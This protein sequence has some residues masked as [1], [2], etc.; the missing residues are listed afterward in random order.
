MSTTKG[1]ASGPV[2]FM[3]V[4]NSATEAVKQGG[5]RRGANMGILRVDHPD[6]IEFIN[7]K[8]DITQ[9]TN[10]NISVAITDVFMDA[11]KTNSNYS[12]INPLNNQV[13]GELNS[14]EVFDMIVDRAHATGEPGVIFIDRINQAN[15]TP[16]L[17]EIESTNPCGEQPLLPYEACNLGS[18]NLNKVVQKQS[19]GDYVMDYIALERITRLAVR[20]LD[21]IIDA[22]CFPLTEI[23]EMVQKT[24]KIGLGVMGWADMLIKLGIPY[25]SDEALRQAEYVMSAILEVGREESKLLAKEK[26]AYKEGAEVRNA[27][28]T[29]I[30]PTGTISIIA[31]CSG[32]VEPLFGIAFIRNQAGEEMADV[33]PYFI[34]VAKERGFYSEELMKK[35]AKQGGVQGL[36]EVPEDI[37]RVWVTS[38]DIS[39]EYHIRMQGAFQK[40]SDS[41]VSKT[42]NFCHSATKKEVEEAY[43]LAYELGCKGTTVYR[44]GS[45]F[46]QAL[47][48]GSVKKEGEV[49][50]ERPEVLRGET[51]KKHIGCGNLY[52]TVNKTEN[53]KPFEVFTNTGKKGGCPSQSEATARMISLALR[54]G[55]SI[56]EITKQLK[57]IRCTSCVGK[58]INVLSCPDAIGRVLGS[59]VKV[60]EVVDGIQCPE[61][62][63]GMIPESGCVKCTE[64]GYSKCG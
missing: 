62:G 54:K 48:I 45:R 1:V 4:F 13:V 46:G 42:I 24:R 11:L 27:T 22:N 23:T 64:C 51:R 38:H 37:R 47:N 26:G 8:S 16:E 15:P 63:K 36:V 58:G 34:E 49:I 57:G 52:I 61:C 6:I 50:E 2:S 12:L 21:N 40:Y 32:G 44:D 9:L 3:K 17:G 10:F 60:V 41:A 33:N 25:N 20:Y 30:A 39:P 5:T 43:F 7:C 59:D 31:N 35:I 56:E 14:R 29:T 28:I 55:I 53:D 19:D 18:I